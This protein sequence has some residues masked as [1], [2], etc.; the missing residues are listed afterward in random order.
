MSTTPEQDR[1]VSAELERLRA[2]RDAL[3][4]QVDALGRRRRRTGALR[5][6]AVIVL[7]VLA[8]LSL[9]AATVAVW[10]NRT[11]LTTDGWVETVGPLGADP[12]VTAALQPRITE[13]VFTAIPAQDL[14]AD[15]L[16]EDRAFLAAPLS[17]AV[18]S[19]V[20]DQVGAFLAS[21][22][23]AQLWIDAN[24]VA[25]ERA[26]A[27]LRGDSDVVQ[28]EGETVT[29]NLLPMVN[30]VLGQLS[31]AAS[32][33]VGQDVNLPTIT[34]GELPEQAVARI[35]EAL[36]VELPPDIGQIPVYGAD[37]LIV[38]Q[39]ALRV[40]DQAFVLVMI[41]TPLLLIAAVWLSQNRRR[42][43]LQLAI[44]S[45]LL[46]VLVRRV[47]LR[48][49]ETIVAMP[50]RPEGQAAAEVVTDQLRGG[51]FELTAAII[52]IALAIVL[53]ALLTGPYRWAVALRRGV[54]SVGRSVWSAGGRLATA[55][56]GQGVTQGTIEHRQALQIGG[57]LVI[58]AVLL[59]VNVPWG[60]FLTLVVLLA[61]WELAL[62]RLGGGG[63]DS[64]APTTPVPQA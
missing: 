17:S 21:D 11:L 50:P 42:T 39:Q 34:S 43:I 13:A 18:E 63:T 25:H 12:T 58:I 35:N 41:A 59:F 55:A 36:G 32:G 57:A 2:E 60:W 33:L 19:F 47:V 29:L 54:G 5:R 30:R 3:Q 8:C 31:S 61:L 44:G 22:T 24:A 38:A 64:D 20:D 37:E 49:E 27:V 45:V 7:V 9:T 16:P 4:T 62:W 6:A 51:L 52:L 10:A 28:V 53:I 1:A 23:F 56:D 46:L 14:I 15:T 26:L 48:F 40:F